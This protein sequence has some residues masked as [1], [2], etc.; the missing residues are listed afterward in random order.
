MQQLFDLLAIVLYQEVNRRNGVL[1]P[2]GFKR[3]QTREVEQGIIHNE[4][5]LSQNPRTLRFALPLQ[6][7]GEG[8]G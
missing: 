5:N 4:L 1:R 2:D 8:G 3:R 6:G 7:G